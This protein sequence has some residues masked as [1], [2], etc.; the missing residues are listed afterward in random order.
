MDMICAVP[1]DRYLYL[2]GDFDAGA[3]QAGRGIGTL[4]FGLRSGRE[5]ARTRS[6]DDLN[7]GCEPVARLTIGGS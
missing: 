1:H 5:A 6:H 7:G 3:G 2:H 4:S